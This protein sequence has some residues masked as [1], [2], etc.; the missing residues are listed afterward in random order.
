MPQL[1]RK[2]KGS[3]IVI[4]ICDLELFGE[5]FQEGDVKLEIDES[6]YGG[7]EATVDECLDALKEATIANM[8]GS[9]VEHAIEIGYVDPEN[10][11]EV[12]GV[13]HAQMARL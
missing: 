9:I 5:N 2:E 13:P 6:F 12:E 11:L 8:V 4:T 7:E 1:S 3:E 10:V